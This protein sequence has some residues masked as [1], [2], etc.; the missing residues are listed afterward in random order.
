MIQLP[1]TTVRRDMM[2]MARMIFRMMKPGPAILGPSDFA[3][4]LNIAKRLLS[5]VGR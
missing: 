4:N 5:F 2:F 1:T 3:E